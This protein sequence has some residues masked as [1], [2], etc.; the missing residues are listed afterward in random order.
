MLYNSY[1]LFNFRKRTDEKVESGKGQLCQR[2]KTTKKYH[3]WTAC[4]QEKTLYIFF[5]Q[6]QVLLPIVGDEK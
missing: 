5:D 3:N 4:T 2:F 6:I 1:V